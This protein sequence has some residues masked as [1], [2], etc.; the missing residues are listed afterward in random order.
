MAGIGK[1]IFL[2]L[3]V[4]NL[5]WACSKGGDEQIL[6]EKNPITFSVSA[7]LMPDEDPGARATIYENSTSLYDEALGGGN[8]M[9]YS[10]PTRTSD[11]YFAGRV[12]YFEQAD[13]WWFR[14]GN[15]IY[16]TYWPKSQNLNF[17]A[18]M[19][20]DLTASNS[21][22]ITVNEFVYASG[23]SFVCNLPKV[24]QNVDNMQEFIYSYRTVLSNELVDLQFVH[25][26]AVVYFK[27]T[28]SHRDLTIHSITFENAYNQGTYSNPMDTKIDGFMHADWIPEPTGTRGRKIIVEKQIPNDINF[29]AEIGGPY[30]VMPQSFEGT[31]DAEDLTIAIEYS[32]DTY[33]HEV[34][35]VKL[36]AV[37]TAEDRLGW[38]SGVKY[39][40]T[41]DM[42][43][44]KEEILFKVLVEKWDSVSYKNE[45]DVE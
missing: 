39:R 20:W 14:D 41:L 1:Y 43:D 44:N 28:Q 9:V 5:F 40:Y 13:K 34:A 6:D 29:D 15:D 4:A 45:I 26:F 21:N 31:T 36:N 27:L 11:C 33:D 32:W 10:Y 38:K 7:H 16:D 18:Y 30:L 17:I 19:P 42:G 35:R 3:I 12:W 24:S 25:P 23:P 8:F 2:F 22:Y 37:G